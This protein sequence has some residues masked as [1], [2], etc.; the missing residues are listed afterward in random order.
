MYANSFGRNLALFNALGQEVGRIDVDFMHLLYRK[1]GSVPAGS[2]EQITRR[3]KE[4]GAWGGYY[5][6]HAGNALVAVM[7]PDRG[8]AGHI[9]AVRLRSRP[10][11]HP[12]SPRAQ[13]GAIP[14]RNERFLGDQARALP[15]RCHGR[16]RDSGARPAA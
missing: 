8:G 7:K 13:L 5:A 10:G 4:T 3:Y 9:L 14:R 16:S 1:S 11:A 2:W 12:Q 15:A 6:A